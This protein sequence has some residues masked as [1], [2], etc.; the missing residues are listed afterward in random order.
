M[1]DDEFLLAFET[2]TLSR[3]EW[4]HEAHIRMAW[5]YL[6]RKP[7]TDALDWIRRGIRK[8]NDRI[9]QPAITHRAPPQPRHRASDCD[10]NGYHETI[11]VALTRI[12]AARIRAGE[13]F[14]N[15]RDLNPDLFDR[16]LPVLFRHYSPSL[17]WSPEARRHL[18]EPD[19]EHWPGVPGSHCP[20][21]AQI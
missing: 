16:K 13:D 7:F 1:T 10:P 4:T 14:A 18:E 6:S 15:F 8:L 5:L 12:I 17:L 20:P 2:C 21:T 11:T 9:G 3:R 19:L